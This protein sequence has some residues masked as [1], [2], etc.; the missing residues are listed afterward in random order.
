MIVFEKPG[1]QNT[2]ATLEMAAARAKKDNV[3]LV[4]ASTKGGC[5]VAAVEAADTMLKSADVRLIGSER[6]GSGLVSVMIRGDVAA[7]QSAI[8]AGSEAAK[9]YGELVSSNVIAR[10]CEDVEGLLLLL[11]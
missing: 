11:D 4:V 8:A 3:H 2:E 5:A 10:P 1:K 9:N 7:V 6:I